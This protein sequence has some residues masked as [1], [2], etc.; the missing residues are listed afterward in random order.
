MLLQLRS[1]ATKLAVFTVC[2]VVA[3]NTRTRRMMKFQVRRRGLRVGIDYEAGRMLRQPPQVPRIVV[4]EVL[5][6]KHH[7][8]AS[9]AP[10]HLAR[11]RTSPALLRSE[12]ADLPVLA[13]LSELTLS[14]TE[15]A[16]RVDGRDRRADLA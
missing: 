1:V 7:D 6:A 4:H 2:E 11:R 14:R 12:L 5:H 16:I 13:N 9:T 8:A 15:S 10:G 3:T